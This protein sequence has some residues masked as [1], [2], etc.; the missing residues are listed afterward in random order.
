MPTKLAAFLLALEAGDP[1]GGGAV[2]K[3]GLATDL[4]ASVAG[5]PVPTASPRPLPHFPDQPIA[6]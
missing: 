1:P 6:V 2:V 5:R 4:A 3:K